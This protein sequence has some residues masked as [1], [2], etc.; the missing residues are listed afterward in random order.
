MKA[1]LI[2]LSIFFFTSCT[3]FLNDGSAITVEK[4]GES[5][6]PS[7]DEVLEDKPITE[8]QPP[9]HFKFTHGIKF[10]GNEYFVQ[11]KNKNALS[12]VRR[13]GLG[14]DFAWSLSIL[15]NPE[16]TS[17]TQTLWSQIRNKKVNEPHVKLQI[18]NGDLAFS[19][20]SEFNKIYFNRL[21]DLD[22]NPGDWYSL[23]LTYTGEATVSE[24]D[25]FKVYISNI[26]NK[27]VTELTPNW[28]HENNGFSGKISGG[29]YIGGLGPKFEG[30]HGVI[31]YMGMSNKLL[32]KLQVSDF[33]LD[34]V[35]WI[36]GE[37]FNPI[38]DAKENHIWMMGGGV[39]D[40]WER[41][42]NQINVEDDQTVLKGKRTSIDSI[43]QINP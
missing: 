31:A 14:E 34:P 5:D 39:G 15:F 20:G 9:K 6:T 7:N 41:I 32:S 18:I 3:S 25:S 38:E 12:P 10:C 27:K 29:F 28:E 19:Y 22:I 37:S 26:K 1:L 17:G 40:T 23:T 24:N 16:F 8:D 21:N 13:R 4:V 30:F 43:I 42:K 35:K 36:N 2:V 11:S 33:S